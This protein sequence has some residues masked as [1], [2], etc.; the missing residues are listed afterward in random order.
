ML[1]GARYQMVAD[2]IRQQILDGTYP[3]GAHLP[4]EAQLA[5]THR[6][7]RELIRDALG[8]LR[9]ED[10]IVTERGRRTTVVP[11][12]ARTPV[13]VDDGTVITAH[14]PA[15]P[16]LAALGCRASTPLLVVTTRLRDC[17]T[18]SAG[19]LAEALSSLGERCPGAAAEVL[20]ERLAE[21]PG[22]GDTVQLA[23]A[24]MTLTSA[25]RR[26]AAEALERLLGRDDIEVTHLVVAIDGL[27]SIA[28]TAGA[29]GTHAR[30]LLNDTRLSAGLQVRLAEIV[31]DLE[32]QDEVAL[33]Y[34]RRLLDEPATA[35]KA[36]LA[37]AA[38]EHDRLNGITI[39]AAAVVIAGTGAG[40]EERGLVVAAEALARVDEEHTAEAVA[41]LEAAARCGSWTTRWAAVTALTGLRLGRAAAVKALLG[42]LD[43]PGLTVRDLCRIA[44]RLATLG[45]RGRD[46][47]AA[48]MV[49]LLGERQLSARTKRAV[50][51]TLSSLTEFPGVE[52]T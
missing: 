5:A 29:A 39:G 51:A 43:E 25:G 42:M 34:L 6:C 52:V 38:A 41:V 48:R 31:T 26:S 44:R 17:E 50:A 22:P 32:P 3:P 37:L 28:A 24:L 12:P 47:G 9:A 10:L 18:D 8:A 36:G 4:T 11:A 7:G 21:T 49:Q 46:G 20:V 13:L 23:Q 2:L 35:R 30:R 15:R 19:A 33:G 16:E 45:P 14:M 40:A 1:P 27:A